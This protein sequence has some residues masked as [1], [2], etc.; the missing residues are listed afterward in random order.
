MDGGNPQLNT[1]N[2]KKQKTGFSNIIDSENVV[3]GENDEDISGEES[4][5][6]SLE[7]LADSFDTTNGTFV[8]IDGRNLELLTFSEIDLQIEQRIEK[9]GGLWKCKVCG[10]TTSDKRHMKEHAETHIEGMSNVCDICRKSF[11]TRTSL[12]THIFRIHS[13]IFNCDIC[14]KSGMHRAAYNF[15]KRTNHKD[16]Q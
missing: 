16:I 15:H 8:S 1:N 4:I 3:K 14:G 9:N 2:S 11:L 10:K 13:A 6:D 5:L 12:S 7:E